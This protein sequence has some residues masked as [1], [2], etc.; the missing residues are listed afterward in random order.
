MKTC[1]PTSKPRSPVCVRATAL[2]VKVEEVAQLQT[3]KA[4][5]GAPAARG[6]KVE[7]QVTIPSGVVRLA[8]QGHYTIATHEIMQVQT[9]AGVTAEAA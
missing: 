5:L 7:L 6:A 2:T 4:M 1:P 9:L 3:L 8:L